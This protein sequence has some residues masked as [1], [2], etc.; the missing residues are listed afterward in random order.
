MTSPL[1]LIH[2]AQ[3][4]LIPGLAQLAD[5]SAVTYWPT[6]ARSAIIFSYYVAL[7]VAVVTSPVPALLVA[8]TLIV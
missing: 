2:L 8:D 7:Y 6:S 4:F 1:F 5:T 3:R